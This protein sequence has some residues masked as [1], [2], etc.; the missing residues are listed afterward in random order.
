MP[1]E[2]TVIYFEE[3]GVYLFLKGIYGMNPVSLEP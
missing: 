1:G 2:V 3:F